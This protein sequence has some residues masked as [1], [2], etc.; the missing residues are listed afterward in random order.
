M[1]SSCYSEYMH[2]LFILILFLAQVGLEEDAPEGELLSNV[3]SEGDINE[4]N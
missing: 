2:R 1:H 4:G 3:N